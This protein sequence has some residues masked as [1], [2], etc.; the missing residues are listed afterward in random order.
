MKRASGVAGLVV[1]LALVPNRVCSQSAWTPRP[2]ED[3]RR[4]GTLAHP[5]LRETSGLVAS[6]AHPGVLW[7]IADSDAPASIFATDTLGS[8]LGAYPLRG[9]RN[10]DWEAISLGPCGDG[11]GDCLYIADTG[12]N[13][14]RRRS[15]A[16]YRL[17]EPTPGAP[18]A[19]ARAAPRVDRLLVRYPDRPRDVE[20]LFV[21]QRGDAHLLSKGRTQGIHHYRVPATAWTR[22]SVLAQAVGTVGIPSGS[23]AGLVTDAAISPDD[24][25][26][27]RTY[28]EVYL[29]RLTRDGELHPSGV[30][31]RLE[32]LD[33]QGEGIAWLKGDDLATSSEGLL[34]LPAT[35]SKGRCPVR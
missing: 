27:V 23:D 22:P 24:I 9:A 33:L 7:S 20:A 3:A 21:D 10:V 5:A 35:I 26:A 1:L 32:G 16:L 29:F 6:R 12:D 18:P 31:C 11:A 30:V 28:H 8:D 17:P 4:T 34:G 19:A 14:E 25:V 13:A 15:V 2:L